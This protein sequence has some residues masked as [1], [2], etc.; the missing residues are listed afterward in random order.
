MLNL[1]AW[2]K[3]FYVVADFLNNALGNNKAMSLEIFRFQLILKNLEKDIDISQDETLWL[4]SAIF[5][6]PHQTE[7]SK[8]IQASIYENDCDRLMEILQSTHTT[9]VLVE[10]ILTILPNYPQPLNLILKIARALNTLDQKFQ[11]LA[12]K[13][14]HEDKDCEPS[15][16]R[17]L[18]RNQYD[19]RNVL[20][21]EPSKPYFRPQRTKIIPQTQRLHLELQKL[22]DSS[23]IKKEM[24]LNSTVSKFKLNPYL[25][26]AERYAAAN[27]EM[28]DDE[29][30]D[31][32]KISQIFGQANYL[33]KQPLM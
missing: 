18:S 22:I 4:I 15:F 27:I 29:L 17:Y 31:L 13:Y 11:M 12:M 9:P 16:L 10:D 24:S 33:A 28:I 25:L 23:V 14:C 2:I 7:W 5:A 30:R 3:H 8:F 20:C 21:I 32:F 26:E 6:L 1:S 19:N